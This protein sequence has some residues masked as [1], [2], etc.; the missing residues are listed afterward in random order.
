MCVCER[1]RERKRE[2]MRE[3]NIYLFDVCGRVLSNALDVRHDLTDNGVEVKYFVNMCA[4][5]QD[6]QI[7]G[8]VVVKYIFRKMLPVG[9]SL[10]GEKLRISKVY[11]VCA[12]LGSIHVRAVTHH[13]HERGGALQHCRVADQQDL[14]RAQ[15]LAEK[16]GIPVQQRAPAS[17]PPSELFPRIDRIE[18][19]PNIT[20]TG[21]GGGWKAQV[22]AGPGEL[23]NIYFG[24]LLAF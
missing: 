10:K 19:V 13:V 4:E 12:R 14:A 7:R 24:L 2:E 1:E 8:Q 21:V 17:R 3:S 23:S 22:G 15:Q 6:H 5:A 9:F 16:C 18:T 11:L 20:R